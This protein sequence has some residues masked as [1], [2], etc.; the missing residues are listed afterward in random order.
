M[1]LTFLWVS[2]E[3]MPFL[4]LL[5][6]TREGHIASMIFHIVLVYVFTLRSKESF[7]LILPSVLQSLGFTYH[8]AIFSDYSTVKYQ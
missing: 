6:N 3:V 1:L 8:L 7:Y 5:G 2:H 4:P